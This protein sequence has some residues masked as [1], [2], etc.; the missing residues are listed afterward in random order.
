MFSTLTTILLIL[1]LALGGS[2]ATVAAAQNSLPD[3]PLYSLKVMS[4]DARLG[5]AAGSQSE[6][7]LALEFANRRA[8]EICAMLQAGKVPPEAV[9]TRYQNLVEQAIRLA[10]GLSN[11]EVA[12]ALEQVHTRLQAQ[13]QTMLQIQPNGSQAVEAVIMRT[14]SMLQE[15][16]QWVDEG[17]SDPARLRMRL[18]EQQRKRDQQNLSTPAGQAA[19]GMPE[20]GAGNPWT[21]GTPTPGSGYGPGAGTGECLNCTP[22]GNANSQGSNPWT[23]GTPT[24]GSGYGPGPGPQPTG[25]CT[26]GASYGPSAQPTQAGPQPTQN[27]QPTQGAQPTTN[28]Q[29]TQP[30]SAPGGP[31]GKP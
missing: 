8:E 18:Q 9:Q 1:S 31:G 30:T 26:P 4:E 7:Q 2:G 29:K 3:E 14:Q 17:L 6:Y 16:L 27:K 19:T 20:T 28:G 21:T 22:T 5:L 11:S 23:T 13:Q 25:T 15:R 12:P 10:A 24:P